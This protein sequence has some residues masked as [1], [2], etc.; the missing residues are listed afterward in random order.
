METTQ[1]APE[2]LQPNQLLKVLAIAKKRGARE[3]AMFLLA[4]AHALRASEI[5]TLTLTDVKNGRIRCARGKKSETT[6]EDLRENQNVLLDEKM[7]LAAWLRVRGEADGS[8]MLFTSRQGSGLTRQQVYNLFRKTL[9]LAG[10]ET[11]HK[12]IHLMKHS[13]ASHLIRNGA[14]L[15]F[16]QKACGHRHI[17]STVR[18]THVTTPEAQSVSNKILANVFAT[19]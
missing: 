4:Y 8:L 16:V 10:V 2:Y 19:A 6:T 15:A 17:S 14:N 12:G 5:A 7:V 18:Y 1:A 3:H 9:E 11:A 13:Y